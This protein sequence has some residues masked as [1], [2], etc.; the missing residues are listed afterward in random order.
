MTWRKTYRKIH[1]QR[2]TVS[3]KQTETSKDKKQDTDQNKQQIDEFWEKGGGS[4]F[5]KEIE[6]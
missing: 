5:D 1:K 2:Q 3:D 6:S 4:R